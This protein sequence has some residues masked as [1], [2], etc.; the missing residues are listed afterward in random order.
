[1]GPIQAAV[2]EQ[3][4]LLDGQGDQFVQLPFGVIGD[5]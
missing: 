4:L 1:M 5:R 2:F 3:F